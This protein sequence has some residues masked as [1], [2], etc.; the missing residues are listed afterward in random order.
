MSGS[1]H[2]LVS[3]TC[4]LVD[5][6]FNGTLSL[7]LSLCGIGRPPKLQRLTCATFPLAILNNTI[8]VF[9]SLRNKV[10]LATK[11]KRD[12]KLYLGPIVRLRVF[13]LFLLSL[14]LS[15]FEYGL[16]LFYLV[17]FAL[18]KLLHQLVY[19]FPKVSALFEKDCIEN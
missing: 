15:V 8:N 18:Q 14:I 5:L 10:K 13:L 11:Q 9:Y 6:V 1:S 19:H 16:A 17:G 12:N 4:I 7:S 2:L 3:L